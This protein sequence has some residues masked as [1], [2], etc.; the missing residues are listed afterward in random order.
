MDK[1]IEDVWYSQA[2]EFDTIEYNGIEYPIK[3]YG[4]TLF[5][6]EDLSDAMIDENGMAKDDMAEDMDDRIAFYFPDNEF[7][8]KTGKELYNYLQ[9][10]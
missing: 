5:A 1:K 4:G 8:G 6:T 3:W 10:Q 7:S 9:T 2:D